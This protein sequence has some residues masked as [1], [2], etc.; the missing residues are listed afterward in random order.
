[1]KIPMGV[2]RA[3]ALPGRLAGTMVTTVHG[4]MGW[5]K[6]GMSS[7]GLCRVILSGAMLLTRDG[8]RGVWR[9]RTGGG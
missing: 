5:H 4:G 2:A 9:E 6:M 7:T 8:E 3:M 1:V